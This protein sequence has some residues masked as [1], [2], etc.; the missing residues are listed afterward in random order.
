[1]TKLPEGITQI[2]YLK[3]KGILGSMTDWTWDGKIQTCCGSKKYYY[4]KVGCKACTTGVNDELK[5][6]WE[7]EQKELKD[8]NQT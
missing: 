7:A 5:D 2:E 3:E 1:M 8:K 4:H 6:L